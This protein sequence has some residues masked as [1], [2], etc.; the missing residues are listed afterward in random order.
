MFLKCSSLSSDHGCPPPVQLR[1][2][3]R[4]PGRVYGAVPRVPYQQSAEKSAPETHTH[5]HT[6]EHENY[7]VFLKK[8][9][10]CVMQLYAKILKESSNMCVYIYIY[11][12]CQ[13]K[14]EGCAYGRLGY[15]HHPHGADQST[16][17]PI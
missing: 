10:G 11:I 14:V 12:Y 17:S 2:R 6:Q 1:R 7:T 8:K 15:R 16:Q 4:P 13:E 9:S 5:T 3:T